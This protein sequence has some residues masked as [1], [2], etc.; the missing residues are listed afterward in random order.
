MKSMEIQPN[1]MKSAAYKSL[2]EKIL[3]LKMAASFI[4]KNLTLFLDILQYNG[5]IE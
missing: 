1:Y 2:G 5:D 4:I 3:K